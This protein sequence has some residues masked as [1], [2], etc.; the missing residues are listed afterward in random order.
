MGGRPVGE[1]AGAR[2]RSVS[3]DFDLPLGAALRRL[4][5]GYS[6]AL[7]EGAGERQLLIQGRAED[8][9][10]VGVAV[11]PAV[12]HM[13]RQGLWGVGGV[14]RFARVVGEEAVRILLEASASADLEARLAAL[15]G[16]AQYGPE[17]V[18]IVAAAA[19]DPD[20]AVR[21]VAVQHLVGEG[22]PTVPHLLKIFR[23]AKSPELRLMALS[24]VLGAGGPLSEDLL[25]LAARDPDP[26]L[27]THAEELSRNGS[28]ARP[29]L[30]EPEFHSVEDRLTDTSAGS[31]P[32]VVVE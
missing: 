28:P 22:P 7:V 21:F 29:S 18:E 10:E 12:G 30:P 25:A 32:V 4:L 15:G 31:Q 14:E 11:G 19:A 1:G 20:P 27:R 3:A 17:A 23:E 8:P 26:R 9:G 16:L 13:P 5:Q 6:F 2:G 24:A